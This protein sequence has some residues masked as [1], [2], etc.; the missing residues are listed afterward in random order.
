MAVSAAMAPMISAAVAGFS[1]IMAIKS[2]AEGNY[3]GALTA[4]LGA[5]AGFG[6]FS[7]A[8]APAAATATL[9][10]STAEVASQAGMVAGD[11]VLASAAD[12]GSSLSPVAPA[13]A[14]IVATAAP[15]ASDALVGLEG[16]TQSAF[17]TGGGGFLDGLADFAGSVGDV[18]KDAAGNVVDTVGNI[19]D[20]VTKQQIGSGGSLW[21]SGLL[22]TG[23][24]TVAQ[25][26]GNKKKM[27]ALDKDQEEAKAEREKRRKMVA[28]TG[29]FVAKTPS[30]WGG[31]RATGVK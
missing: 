4:G 9:P 27:E 13:A 6:A 29:N 2:L 20:P 10:A 8:A 23:I 18:V 31:S 5:A 22:K 19:F 3:L 24:G 7:S 26:Y 11:G 1:T 16:L 30:T 25:L 21:D 28:S 14:D 12:I 17:S 15:V